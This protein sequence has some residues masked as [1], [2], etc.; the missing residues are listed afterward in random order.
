M[1]KRIAL[2]AAVLASTLSVAHADDTISRANNTIGISTGS[3]T[4]DYR[5]VD[6]YGMTGTGTLDSEKGTQFMFEGSATRQGDVFGISDVYTSLAVSYS[7]GTTNYDGYLQSTDGSSAALIP[8][9]SS[10]TDSTT[11]VTLKVGKGFRFAA[12]GHPAQVT[13]YVRYGFHNWVRN[14][15]DGS[16]YGYKETYS[17]NELGAGVLG[18]YAFTNKLVGSV[19]GSVSAT[20]SPKMKADGIGDF[21]LKS[22]ATETVSVGFDYAVTPAL[23][24]NGRYQFTHFEYGQSDIS[25]GAF[26]PTSKTNEHVVL[27]GVGYAF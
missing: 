19:D 1:L 22:K 26:E 11:D 14:L 6:N 25:N 3:H 8:Y 5:E 4:L 15:G 17:H 10:T 20:I 23:H 24:V 21:S 7:H 13:P 9:Q 12:A 2:A 16:E 18:Q 27:V